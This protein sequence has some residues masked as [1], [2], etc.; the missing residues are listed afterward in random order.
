MKKALLLLHLLALSLLFAESWTVLVYM[1][2]DNNLAYNGRMNINEM[3][4]AAQAAG[5]NL[6]VQADFPDVGAKRYRI[7]QDQNPNQITSPVLQNLGI[8]DSGDPQSLKDFILWGRN[9]YPA[10]NYMLV[11]WAHGDSWYKNSKWIAPDYDSGSVIGVANGEL[12]QAL[13]GTGLWDI[14]LF[15]ACSMQ[16]IEVITEV[17]G[18]A[19]FIVGSADL[20]PATGFPYAE[21]IPL[22]AQSP[23][24]VAAQIPD[25]YIDSYS[26]GGINN[27]S[28][29]YLTTT[30]SA[31]STLGLDD[32]LSS[33]KNFSRLL[34]DQPDTLFGIRQ[35]LFE[36][37]TGYADVDIRQMLT[38]L[39]E[40][41]VPQAE[42]LL[43]RWNNLV[44]ASGYTLPY[45]ETDIGTAAIW[46]PDIRF[47]YNSAWQ[48]YMQLDFA[49]TGWLGVVNLCL[50]QPYPELDPPTLISSNVAIDRLLLRFAAPSSPDS[51]YYEITVNGVT[52]LLYP[53]AYSS[54]MDFSTVVTESGSFRIIAIDQAGQESDALSGNF[55]IADPDP[56]GMMVYPNPMRN[57]LA[58]NLLWKHPADANQLAVSIYNI[59]GQRVLHK[60]Y[61]NAIPQGQLPLIDLEGIAELRRGIYFLRLHLQGKQYQCKL[62]IL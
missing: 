56:I 33:W 54:E 7:R 52:H 17:A 41:D 53:A 11:I 62:S 58:G 15:D 60:S 25:L 37:N 44:I 2:A 32:F 21:I 48:H 14:L 49:H 45:P 59:K 46:F 29:G 35:K 38:R 43:N 24:Q 3:E 26:P 9:R 22:L 50:G 57:V 19:R 12:R 4:S 1:A 8:I 55:T 23:P 18:F 40:I 28:Q 39:V 16:S 30:C 6:I 20:V 42:A 51:L 31:I 13:M 34:R 47:N 10:D 27:P 61:T 5:L 36:M